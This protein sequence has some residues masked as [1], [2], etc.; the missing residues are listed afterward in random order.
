MGIELSIIMLLILTSIVAI[1]AKRI[2]IPYTVALVSVGLFLG[3]ANV[4]NPPHLSKELLYYIFLPPLIFQSAIHLKFEDVK[5]DFPVILTLVVPGVIA[6]TFVT[7][8]VFVAIGADIFHNS[9]NLAIGLLFGAAVAA[10]DPVAVINIFEKLGVPRRLRFLVDSESLLND[11]TAIVIFTLMLEII[12]HKFSSLNYA[13][14]DFFFVVGMGLLIGYIIGLFTDEII[15]KVDDPMVVITLTTIAAYLSFIIADKMNV[16]G[17]MSTVAAGLVIGQR[18]LLNPVYPTIK[19]TTETFWEYIVFLA[20]SLIFLLIGFSINIQ[21]LYNL[22]PLILIAYV[23]MMSARFLVIFLTWGIFSKTGFSFPFKWS[24]VMGWGGIRGALTMV[25]AMSLPDSFRYKEIIITLVF[26]VVLL[27]IFIQGITMPFLIKILKLNI[28]NKDIFTYEEMK[29]K[30][31]IIEYMINEIN[32]LKS[33]MLISPD[34]YNEF[35]QE[36]RN[37]LNIL[38]QNIQNFETNNI[39]IKNEEILKT[40]RELLMKEKKYL[41]DMYH[42]GRISNKVYRKILNEM[43]A[44]LFEIEN[45]GI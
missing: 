13:V 34:I 43:D 29:T 24:L 30:I 17:V 28:S 27:S 4:F 2:N 19:L 9:V 20:N 37:E 7:A 25:L 3:Y 44:K 33:K 38:I 40:K 39:D 32:D 31:S 16:S 41:L 8:F 35:L 36:Y 18:S 21:M 42:N 14:I 10:T 26:G 12:N 23:A 5:R 45:M 11:G 1:L 22:W 6:S 15:K